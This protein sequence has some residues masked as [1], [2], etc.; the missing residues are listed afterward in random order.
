MSVG[1]PSANAFMFEL[2]SNNKDYDVYIDVTNFPDTNDFLDCRY[3]EKGTNGEWLWVLSPD[4]FNLEDTQ[5]TDK[6]F[7]EAIS[8]INEKLKKTFNLQEVSAIPDKG[9]DRLKW[10]LSNRLK[11]SGKELLIG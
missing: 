7:S 3:R 1:T 5:S 6:A 9:V 11:W 8:K 4:L 2:T 10:L